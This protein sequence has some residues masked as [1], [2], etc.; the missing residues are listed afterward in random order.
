MIPGGGGLVLDMYVKSQAW[1]DWQRNYFRNT[2]FD[3]LMCTHFGSECEVCTFL[4]ELF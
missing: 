3:T 1:V 2:Q 4:K